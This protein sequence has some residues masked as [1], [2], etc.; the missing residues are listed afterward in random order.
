MTVAVFGC[1]IDQLYPVEN[2]KLAEEITEKGLTLSE[3][4]MGTPAYPQNFPV[5]NR[6]ISGMSAGVVVVEGGE[7]SGS[8][9]TAKLAMEQGREVFAVPGNITSKMSW[10]PNLLIKQGA[11]L[12]QEWNDVLSELRPEDRRRLAQSANQLELKEI[13]SD[14]SS[15]SASA[16]LTPA[17]RDV[18]RAL[19]PDSPIPLDQL[20]ETL[21]GISSSE[22]IATLFELELAGLVRQVPGKSFL[23]VWGA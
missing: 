17:G 1:G 13:S 4:P 19:K 14:E 15:E 20:L 9:I 6:I 21:Q 18:L 8:A 23:R 2:R 5:R 16:S 12:I 3:F 10:G 11:R 22:I 7:Y